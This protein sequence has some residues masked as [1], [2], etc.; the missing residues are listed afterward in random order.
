MGLWSA[1]QRCQ[2]DPEFADVLEENGKKIKKNEQQ[3]APVAGV[4]LGS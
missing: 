3:L 1:V 4:H 2:A